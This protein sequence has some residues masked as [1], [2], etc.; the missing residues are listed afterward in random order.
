M[1]CGQPIRAKSP[2][3][4]IACRWVAVE[5]AVLIL[6]VGLGLSASPACAQWAAKPPPIDPFAR[7][8]RSGDSPD[9][10]TVNGPGLPPPS[11]PAINAPTGPVAAPPG[12]CYPAPPY[13]PHRCSACADCRSSGR[14]VVGPYNPPPV[15][16]P[17][18][19][20]Q[21]PQFQDPMQLQQTAPAA[22]NIPTKDQS[23]VPSGTNSVSRLLDHLEVNGVARGYYLN[24]QRIEWSGMEETFG[25]EGDYH[26][27][28]SP[29][30][31]RFRIRHRQRV[32]HQRAL[33]TAINCYRTIA[34]RKSYAANFQ[35]D[36]FEISQ[37]ALVTNYGDWTFKIGKFVTPFGRY[38]FSALYQLA[39][40]TRR[41]SARK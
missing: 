18:V 11:A 30:V 6:A 40:G 39:N 24:D 33:S 41:S 20:V 9:G 22:D 14:I 8:A 19:A 38:L 28:A 16:P 37:L 13:H 26:A 7:V 5:I 21:G 4:P 29:A 25:A 1:A 31:R 23:L 12:A 27:P 34:E 36:Q 10:G 2:G 3:S 17:P 32:L 35:V 15:A